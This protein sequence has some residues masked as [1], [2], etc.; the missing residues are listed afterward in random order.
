MIAL[1]NNLFIFLVIDKKNVYLIDKH[2]IWIYNLHIIDR[3]INTLLINI[4]LEFFNTQF[5]K[6]T[7]IYIRIY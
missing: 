5:L 1:T 6:I 2:S 4:I 7:N 3:L